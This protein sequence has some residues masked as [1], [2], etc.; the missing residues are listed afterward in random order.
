MNGP[1][2]VHE[3]GCELLA[4]AIAARV[5]DALDLRGREGPVE[6]L[7]FVEVAI[8]IPARVA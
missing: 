5:V 7:H 6:E 4:D 2:N 3:A 1:R 8:E